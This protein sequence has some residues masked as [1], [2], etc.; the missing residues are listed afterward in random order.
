MKIIKFR[1]WDNKDKK[2]LY[3]DNYNELADIFNH[4]EAGFPGILMQF[5]GLKDKNGKEIYE[6]DIIQ[7]KCEIVYIMTNKPTGKMSIENYEVKWE[8]SRGRWG[9]INEK[10]EFES[11]DG[12]EKESLT[13]WYEVIGNIYENPELLK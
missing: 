12:L 13:R 2:M 6:G 10:K 4:L 3:F 1:C 8:E 7:C 9:R 11:L 5:T